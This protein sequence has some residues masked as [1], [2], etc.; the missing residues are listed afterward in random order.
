V[1]HGIDYSA[2]ELYE[3]LTMK[4]AIPFFQVVCAIIR[5]PVYPDQYLVAQRQEND[6]DLPGLWEFPGGK[7][8]SGESETQALIREIKEELNLEI[9]VCEPLLSSFWTYPRFRIE[10]IPYLCQTASTSIQSVDHQR[11][12]WTHRDALMKLDWA[13]ADI[14]IVEALLKT[15][16]A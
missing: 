3:A 12:E 13:P 16:T 2:H 10:L 1:D 14:P 7:I 5:H 11:V 15:A 6:P 9:T 8:E 4:D